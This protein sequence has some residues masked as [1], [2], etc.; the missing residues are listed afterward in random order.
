MF[1]KHKYAGSSIKNMHFIHTN[2]LRLHT[3]YFQMRS[4][5]A[6]NCV[7]FNQNLQDTENG[8]SAL[9]ALVLTQ[10]FSGT[11]HGNVSN[12]NNVLLPDMRLSYEFWHTSTLL[13]NSTIGITACGNSHTCLYIN[14]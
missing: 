12:V 14:Y 6:K 9:T 3:I 8:T 5:V 13:F 7:A 11:V 1:W 10:L 4:W 2:L